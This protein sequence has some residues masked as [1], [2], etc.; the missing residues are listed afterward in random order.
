MK[1]EKRNRLE[2]QGWKVGGATEFLGLTIV[3]VKVVDDTTLLVEFSNG[4][5]RR[6]SIVHLLDKPMFMPLRNPSFF[7]AF[8]VDDGGYGIVW[9]DEIDL[10]EYELWKNGVEVLEVDCALSSGVEIQSV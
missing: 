3:S 7:R 2:A 5:R 9:N 4:D 6:Y 1:L 8:S 10:S